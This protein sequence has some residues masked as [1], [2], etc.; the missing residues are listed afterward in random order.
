MRKR[1]LILTVTLFCCLGYRGGCNAL[2]AQ[3]KADSISVARYRVSK[4]SAENSDD[5]NKISTA[6]LKDPENLSREP[7]YEEQTNT[8]RLGTRLGD[9]Y[10][11]V[12][13]LMT[14]QEYNRWSM[15]KSMQEYFRQKNEDAY[16]E[17]G[18]DKFDFTD[19]HFD[20]GPAEKIF[21]PGGVRIR[22][23]GSASVKFG[24]DRNVI[25]NPSL[26]PQN[27]KTFGF[28]FDEQ[29]NINVNATVGDKIDMT[30]N[31]NTEATFNFDTKNIR[32]RYEGKEDE[33]IKLVEAGDISFPTN[34][35]LISGSTSLFGIRTDLQFGKLSLQTVISQKNTSSSTV[36]STGGEQMSDFEIDA[37]NYDENRHFFLSHYF[38]DTY[39]KNMSMLPTVMS[40]IN[41][42]RIEVWVTN[43][44]SSYD[45]PRHILA[46]TDLAESEHITNANWKMITGP[47]PD[48]NDNTLYPE[49]LTTYSSVRHTDSIEIAF[50]GIMDGG[51][52]YEKISNA[53]KLNPSEYILNQSLGYISLRTALTADEVLAVAFEYTY[54]NNTY[55]VGEFST[56]NT[57]PNQA[58]FLKLLKSNSNSPGSGTWDLMMKNVYAIGS[59][60]LS[61]KDFKLRIQY[62]SDS[63]GSRLNYLPEP[64]LQQTTLLQLMELDRLDDKLEPH[65][66]GQFDYIDGYT[67]IS[68]IARIVFPVVEPFGSHL[69]NKID[70]WSISDKYIFQEMYDST[71]T[72]AKRVAQKDKF[73]LTGQYAGSSENVIQLGAYN[74]PRGSVVVTAGG[75][76]LIENVDYTVDYS[77]GT[78]TIINQSIIEAGT[79][80]SVSLE[81]NTD[82]SM[83][84]KTMLGM[85]W[86]YDFSDNFQLG[87]TVLHLNER[88]LTSKVSMGDEPLVNT[89]LGVNLNWR[90]ES[91]AITNLFDHLPFV[92][93]TEPSRIS[94]SAEFA[95][96]FSAV[97]DNV[98]GN[99]SYVDDFETAIAGIDVSNPSAWSLASRPSDLKSRFSAEGIEGGF[100][101]A[102]LNWFT[103]DPLFTRRNSSLTPAHIKNDL[104]Q[105]S[106]HYVREVYERELYPN[107]ES[108]SSEATT[109][110]ILNLAYYPAE[111]G[112]YNLNPNLT[113][114]GRLDTTSLK[115]NWG[116]IMRSLTTT[117]FETANIEYMEFWM[118]D[119][120]IYTPNAEGG[121]FI[122]HLG[123][124]S[125]DILKDGRKSF[126]NG[127][128]TDGDTTKYVSTIW[129]RVPTTT[130]LVY[131]FD[132]N[133]AD[134][135]KKQDVG[136]NGL[137]TE[138]E[139][140]F[141][142]YSHYL[143]QIK[144][145]LSP[146]AYEEIYNDP[147]N[148][149][150]H[151]FRGDDYD[152]AQTPIL[153][154]YKRFNGTEGN[155]PNADETNQRYNTSAKN[156]PDVEDVNSD[157]TMDEYE[158]YFKYHISLR[159]QDLKV[160]SNYI[161]D[162]RDVQVKLRNDNVE[163]VTW[164]CFRVPI[165]QY[166]QAIGGIRDF[167]SIRFMR[168]YLTGFE[169][170]TH[171]RFGT[172]EL[173]TSQWRVYEQAI[174]NPSTKTAT[175]SGTIAAASVNIEENG[176]R[177]PVNYVVPPGVTRILDPSQ[178]Q[179]VQDNEQSM[180]MVIKDLNAGDARGIYKKT[181][182]DLRKYERIQ[183]FN[184][185]EA[186][187]DDTG[188]LKDGDVSVFIRLGS[189]YS[190]NFYEYEIPLKL[191]EPGYYNGDS[192]SDREKVWPKDN[193]LDIP[194][195]V[196][197]SVKNKRRAASAGAN[198]TAAFTDYDPEHPANR[199]TVMGNP[200]I[201]NV[202]AIM[203]GV[204]NN[205][206]GIR[207]AT[208][209][210]NELRLV[211]YESHGGSAAQ[212]DLN[213]QVSDLATLD[214]KGQYT[215]AGFGG[216][217]QGVSERRM[218]NFYKYSITTN[219]NAGR[220]LPEKAQVSIPFYY[221]YSHEKTSPRYS[222]FDTD[223][224]LNDVIDSY[225]EKRERDSIRNITQEVNTQK[226]LSITG[227]AVNISS[228]KPMPYDPANFSFGYS[229]SVQ[230]SKGSTIEYEKD[231]RWKGS[232]NYNY[233]SPLD[234]IKP[235]KIENHKSK[236]YDIIRDL[237][238]APIPQQISFNTDLTRNYHELQERNLDQ[239]SMGNPIPVT[240]SQQFYWNRSLTL[241]WDIFNS[242]KLSVTTK[243]QAEI[244]EPY[245]VVNKDLYPDQYEV[246]KD[247]VK[248]SLSRLGK[249]LDFQQDFTA[250]YQLP[251]NKLPVFDWTNFSATYSAQYNWD[252]G[253]TYADGR[254]FGNII[255][256]RRVASANGKLDFE[257]L[258][259]KSFYLRKIN[260]RFSG[261]TNRYDQ[262]RKEA[263]L[264]E[265]YDQEV[266]IVPGD[267][268]IDITHN[269]GTR[270]P[271]VTAITEDG[272]PYKLRYKIKDE[273]T[274]SVAPKDSV[275]LRVTI[276]LDPHKKNNAAKTTMGDV[277]DFSV[278]F[279]MAIRNLSV[280]YKNDYA[281]SIPGFMPGIGKAFGQKNLDGGMAPGLD[282]AFGFIGDSYLNKVSERGWLLNND[283]VA[284]NASTNSANDLQLKMGLEPVSGL[285]ID[286]NSS[287]TRSDSKR[288]Q[289]MYKGMP[290]TRTGT[291][292]MTTITIGSAFEPRKVSNDYHSAAFDKF[293]EN[294]DIIQDRLEQKY[295]GSRYPEQSSL[296][297][298][299]YDP[300][301][302]GV[303]KYSADVMIPAFLAAYTGRNASSAS[304]DIFPSILSML[305]NWSITFNG[306]S[307]IEFFKNNFQSFNITHGYKSIYS[308]G[309]YN[310]FSTYMEYMEDIG[311]IQDAQTGNPVP[312]SMYDI[313]AV[314][315]NESFSPLIGVNMT[316]NNNITAKLELRKTRVM[317]L[318][319]A[320]I[321]LVET[322]SDDIVAG[323][324]YKLVNVKMLGARPGVGKNKVSNDLNM[325]CDISYRNQN[326]LCRNISTLNTQAT[327]GNKAVK[328]AFS[329]DYTYSKMLT[330]NFY[331]NFQSNF[332]LVSTSAFPTSTHDCG[333]TIKF[334]LAR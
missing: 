239:F 77:M 267:E 100:E 244:E 23:N 123:E 202:R 41:I 27:R 324:G 115:S 173:K 303:N 314:S 194:L 178:S 96:L 331:Y 129:G 59:G 149:N 252:R 63:I 328:V 230:D 60:T 290:S 44:R 309:S 275:R 168:M 64:F 29:I 42:T 305:P 209:W 146:T 304:T 257:S 47:Q 183:M 35:S 217:E 295:K 170:E 89:M 105:L 273:N 81:S 71:K 208:I 177:K 241:R 185:A 39:D 58:L 315:I 62:A 34:S 18:K 269:L 218:D 274:I 84:R 291:F 164:Y 8:Y 139:R 56:D 242:L 245:C 51:S 28:D 13:M 31:Y 306:L 204:R 182:L 278:R 151:Y 184:H 188:I 225:V 310:T 189:D 2:F 286:L 272:T 4:T 293:C 260:D 112:P 102:M 236:W 201:G 165:N 53:R 101:R 163:E 93:A 214:V 312:S 174:S 223:I 30:L 70:D 125:E 302:G 138:D 43:K 251:I 3:S 254:T 187:L 190:S 300:A 240:F 141:P 157:Y 161:V 247:S 147:A 120:F 153:K 134:N 133:D 264:K 311:F 32:L 253:T 54:G 80:V 200:S 166:E 82:F 313:G 85:N 1:L 145:I 17:A 40:G 140:T 37:V 263:R 284:Y 68:S 221:S 176:D 160:G 198:P 162:K 330:L 90:K 22:T 298:Q 319:M 78:V 15:N 110:A 86:K 261:R 5:F 323:A 142:T 237:S 206:L 152:D 316:M 299:P 222:P 224:E 130:S 48:N 91:Q 49:L 283:S 50:K 135:R 137:S 294:L 243:T 292:N 67:V 231:L 107:K 10:L 117:D 227:A 57:D 73:F 7:E 326:A 250:S 220:F 287:W 55:Q 150:Y 320:A 154:R 266:A 46:F 238:I 193:M 24:F 281:M 111:R 191:T 52:D 121:D 119:P 203:I 106:N 114:D 317:N 16:N 143:S 285:K 109:L 268:N 215:T 126:E 95:K 169:Q 97:S 186:M 329:A 259:N 333:F 248:A 318:S 207:S 36:S 233:T 288:I 19:M 228:K 279:L 256:N 179:L 308:V 262:V 199:I 66:N 192:E 108:T 83:Q 148:D 232:I 282:F 235:F 79:N 289:Y 271:L 9:D 99:A 332:P 127:L 212:G 211:G 128:P 216:L 301:N 280:T 45:N 226:N 116:G 210:V 124:V 132:N 33:I 195:S 88:P 297:G 113:T 270:T 118:L 307:K 265:K 322:T 158:K 11:D 87:G 144:D 61:K 276:K 181:S 229:R 14:P 180:S 6:D 167:S 21:G 334:A 258:Y 12:P 175:I 72:V 76:T 172:L 196:L 92:S 104:E 38:R 155:S 234:Y 159:P 197:T 249:P 75:A 296:P 255:A 327:S 171:I 213:V 131:A 94:L 65:P 25:D 325:N 20:L 205:S 69:K 26:S 246:W 219:L 136:Y 321:Q 98:Q 74:I 277:A 122:I 156:T 103:I